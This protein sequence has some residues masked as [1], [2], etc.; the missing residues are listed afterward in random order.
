MPGS[1]RDRRAV[2]PRRRAECPLLRPGGAA[3]AGRAPALGSA[4]GVGV[5]RARLRHRPLHRPRVGPPAAGPAVL[6]GGGGRGG[7]AGRHRAARRV[8]RLAGAVRLGRRTTPAP[9]HGHDAAG[10]VDRLPGHRP[11][12]GHGHARLAA[13]PA[14]TAAGRGGRPGARRRLGTAAAAAE[15]ARLVPRGRLAVAAGVPVAPHRRRGGVRVAHRRG[16][17]R[18]G[19]RGRGGPAGARPDAAGAAARPSVRAVLEVA[20]HRL[21]PGVAPRR[22]AA[23]PGRRAPGP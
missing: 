8:R 14:A 13:H 19:V 22:A 11:G 5:R 3:A 1:A 16:R 9:R 21:R 17:G 20:G 6:P 15:P 18:P 23:A 10:L 2:R 4:A 12:R 7:G